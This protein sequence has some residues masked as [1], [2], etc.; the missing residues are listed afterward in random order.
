MYVCMCVDMRLLSPAVSNNANTNLRLGSW[1][2]G[3][4]PAGPWPVPASF[5]FH[6]ASRFQALSEWVLWSCPKNSCSGYNRFFKLGPPS[7]S[8][9]PFILISLQWKKRQLG[10]SLAGVGIYPATA[11]IE[12]GE[13]LGLSKQTLI[14]FFGM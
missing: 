14:P 3:S 6:T 12:T 11:L 9:V 13:R 7:T 8:E 5:C 4:W 10:V 2:L 1:A